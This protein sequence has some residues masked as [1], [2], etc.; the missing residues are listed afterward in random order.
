MRYAA[1]MMVL[2]FVGCGPDNT[3]KMPDKPMTEPVSV[4]TPGTAGAGG[5]AQGGGSAP[6]A[7]MIK[8]PGR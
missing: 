2:V 4:D 1:L 3:V 5:T 6:P 8:R 7:Q